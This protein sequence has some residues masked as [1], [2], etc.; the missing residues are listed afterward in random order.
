M[1]QEQQKPTSF[2]AL[3]QEAQTHDDYWVAGA[4]QDFT[5]EVCRLMEIQK[6]SRGELARRL[7]SSP[8]YVTKI[9]RGNV[10]FTLASM[11]KVARA[12]GAE[13]RVGLAVPGQGLGGRVWLSEVAQ[14][15]AKYGD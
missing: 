15:P 9:L 10:N 11:V 12:L 6:V 1:S 8:A 4:I 3:Y 14:T 7:G 13:L 5:E 2:E